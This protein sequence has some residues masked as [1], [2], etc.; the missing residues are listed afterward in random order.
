MIC[1][2]QWLTDIKD[3]TLDFSAK[4]NKRWKCK[5]ACNYPK[6]IQEEVLICAQLSRGYAALGALERQCA[7][8][9]FQ[10]PQTK[11]WLFDTLV[12]PT[13]LYGVQTWGPSLNKEKHWRDLERFSVNDCPHDKEQ[14]IGAP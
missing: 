5:K 1:D 14:S 13:L 12:T 9:Q 3:G 8:L 7:H 2:E 6:Q 11:L 4:H 10:E